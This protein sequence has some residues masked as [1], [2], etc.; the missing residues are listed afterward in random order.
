MTWD[1]DEWF[2]THEHA[3]WVM[4][5]L[6]LIAEG[7]DNLTYT[8]GEEPPL[9]PVRMP[10]PKPEVLD[11][12]EI[13][14]RQQVDARR[15]AEKE[16]TRQLR[17]HVGEWS[18]THHD[19]NTRDLRVLRRKAEMPNYRPREEWSEA[20]IEALIDCPPAVVGALTVGDLRFKSSYRG[21]RPVRES[22]LEHLERLGRVRADV[23][24]LAGR[25]QR[26]GG[27]GGMSDDREGQPQLSEAEARELER[28]AES[29]QDASQEELEAATDIGDDF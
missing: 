8:P 19:C 4:H 23:L 6:E 2:E 26:P 22:N 25:A 17:E 12:Y 28:E 13:F 15:A 7:W 24:G 9:V 29:I 27:R 11:E 21:L 10:L 1:P 3:P 20:E 16:A 14:V 18:R 5:T